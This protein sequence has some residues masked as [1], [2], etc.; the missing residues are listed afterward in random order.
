MAPEGESEQGPL[1]TTAS[2]PVLAAREL[3]ERLQAIEAAVD[4]LSRRQVVAGLRSNPADLLAGVGGATRIA[5][6]DV[7][8]LAELLARWDLPLSQA[9]MQALRG[10]AL[11][12]QGTY[13]PAH[14]SLHLVVDVVSRSR[15][16]DLERLARATS[17]LLTRSRR[18]VPVLVTLHE[19]E[20]D[21]V[22]T[23]LN[24]G[25]ELVVDP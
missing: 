10:V 20:D 3:D 15:R 13:G 23:A 4:R 1:V 17:V 25:I 7:D 24:L 8:E 2:S 22:E 12:A 6:Q 11:L 5:R 18:A 14:A 21:S 9:E 16:S 19:P